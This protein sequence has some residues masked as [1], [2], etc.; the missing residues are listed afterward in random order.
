MASDVETGNGDDVAMVTLGTGKGDW[1]AMVTLG[2]G[3]SVGTVVLLG[4]KVGT[5]K[6]APQAVAIARMLAQT[7]VRIIFV[8]I[9]SFE[10][11]LIIA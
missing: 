1:V 4:D 9:G 11:L 6:F 5:G 7:I 2:I 3:W 8:G 10:F